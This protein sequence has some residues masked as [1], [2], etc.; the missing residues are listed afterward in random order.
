MRH[1]IRLLSVLQLSQ[2]QLQRLQSV[3]TELDIQQRPLAPNQPFAE[4]V[5]PDIEILYTHQRNFDLQL[6]P[7][8]R[9]VQLDSAGVNLLQR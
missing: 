3:S 4:V 5:T 2:T 8:L 7:D 6:V 9:W 1:H